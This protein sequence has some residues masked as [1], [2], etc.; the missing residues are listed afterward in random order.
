MRPDDVGADEFRRAL[1]RTIHM[2]LGR[3]MHDRV[4]RERI[5]RALY[6]TTVA[7]VGLGELIAR[8]VLDRVEGGKARRVGQL[9]DIE[10]GPTLLEHK[11]PAHGRAD[12]TSTSG[13]NNAHDG[14]SAEESRK[15][16]ESGLTSIRI[17]EMCRGGVDGPVDC[18]VGVVPQKTAVAL[19]RV[20]CARLVYDLGIGFKRA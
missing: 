2:G 3:E 4:R 12:E 8:V 5:E 13:H 11:I 17:R 14:Q 10:D 20:I 15:L 16:A 6:G 9:V 18:K 1:D 7:D 19:A